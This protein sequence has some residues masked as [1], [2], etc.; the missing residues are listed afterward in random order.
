MGHL[1][2][3][4]LFD[5]FLHIDLLAAI[6]T[7]SRVCKQWRQLSQDPHLY[8]SLNFASGELGLHLS[9]TL[10]KKAIAMCPKV[11]VINMSKTHIT[12][13]G[14]DIIVR[15]CKELRE[16]DLSFCVRLKNAKYDSLLTLPHFQKLN[17]IGTKE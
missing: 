13:A 16:L 6:R 1:P 2:D 17:I 12:S 8:P 15:S 11:Q 4:T 3:E 9:D 5:I 7:V 14:V 10:F